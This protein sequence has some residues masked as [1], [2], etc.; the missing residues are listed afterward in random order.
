[1]KRSAHRLPCSQ[2]VTSNLDDIR[3]EPFLIRFSWVLNQ[4]LTAD[5]RSRITPKPRGTAEHGGATEPD[6][7]SDPGTSTL[8]HDEG[9]G[10]PP[11]TVG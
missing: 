11:V 3:F 8:P 10:T 6:L 1:M 4:A 9:S 7:T 2:P 5:T